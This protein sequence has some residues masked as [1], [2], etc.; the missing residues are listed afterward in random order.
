MPKTIP[1]YENSYI[2]KLCCR[3]ATIEHI[4]I[5]STTNMTKR[6]CHH[7]HICNNPNRKEYNYNV[8]RHIRNTYLE[9]N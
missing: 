8:Y 5:G 3:D 4:Y 9:K 2:Y 7:K 1:D 6:K